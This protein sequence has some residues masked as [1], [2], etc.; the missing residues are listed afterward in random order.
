MQQFETFK[1]RRITLEEATKRNFKEYKLSTIMQNVETKDKL[2]IISNPTTKYIS[3]ENEDGKMLGLI[4]IDEIEEM[5]A[6]VKVSIPN[7]A[8]EKRYGKETIHQFIKCCKERKLYKRLYFKSDNELVKEYK[9]ERPEMLN[10]N[11][12]IDIDVA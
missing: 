3:V 2:N 7:K 12:Y 1:A 10:K 8:W 9:K 6:C 5:V 4:R 11:Y